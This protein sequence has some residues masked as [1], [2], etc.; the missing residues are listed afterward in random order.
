MNILGHDRRAAALSD[1]GVIK[2]HLRDVRQLFDAMDPSPFRE[3]DLDPKAQEYITDSVHELPSR[4]P[5]RL[6]IYL[7]H[8]T[9]LLDETKKIGDAVRAHFNRQSTLRWR[10][11]RRLIRRGLISLAIGLLFLISLFALAQFVSQWMKGNMIA[12]L[13]R[14][15]LMIGGWVAMWRPLEIFLYDWWPIV[16]EMRMYD[17]LS[18]IAVEVGQSAS[19]EMDDLSRVLTKKAET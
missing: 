10:D 9:D 12:P 7:D 4:S 2:V 13:V 18:R 8:P 1:D 14:E 16:G 3:K 15:G 6:V 17:R 5:A 11:L 19:P